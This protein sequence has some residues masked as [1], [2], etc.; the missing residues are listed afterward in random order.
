MGR[1]MDIEMLPI[2]C[3]ST[4]LSNTSPSDACR[5]SIVSS[6][7]RSAAESDVVW[8]RFLPA[9]Y[10]DVVS[11]LVTPLT[12]SAMKE[13]FLLLCNPVL[14]DGGKKSFKLDKSSGKISYMLSAR[15]ISITG[16]DEPMC[17]SWRS[18]PESRFSEVA[19]LRTTSWLEIHG[20]IR[21]QSLSPNTTYGAY[22][23]LQTCDRAYGLDSIPSEIS[24]SV[25][26]RLFNGTAYLTRGDQKKQQMEC[27]FYKNR[28]EILG[29]RVG[30]GDG[31]VPCKREDGW[32]EI[33]LGEFFSSDA[34]EEVNMSLME[35]KGHQLKGGL[36]IEGIELRP[37]EY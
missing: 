14:I 31:R 13:L 27:L 2:D 19:E 32:M 23:V 10:R 36:V 11:R 12:F 20:K 25:G 24:V 37:K 29:K 9:E 34:S 15:E 16:S 3:V 17:W 4:I 33:E 21:T 22:L 6:T 28:I 35:V 26:N 30:E 7:F 8:K 5:S 1:G 18:V